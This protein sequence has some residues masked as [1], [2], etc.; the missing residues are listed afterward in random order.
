MSSSVA[1]RLTNT[2]TPK[3]SSAAVVASLLAE[4][5]VKTRSGLSATMRSRLGSMSAPTRSTLRAWGG[6][7]L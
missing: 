4:V 5:A 6:Q 1:T 2:G 7:S 3:R